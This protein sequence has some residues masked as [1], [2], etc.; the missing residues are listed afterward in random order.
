[1]W[2][3]SYQWCRR[4]GIVDF[5]K[6]ALT[7]ESKGYPFARDF[8]HLVEESEISEAG[9]GSKFAKTA[10]LFI[11]FKPENGRAHLTENFK[12]LDFLHAKKEFLNHY[13]HVMGEKKKK[14][15]NRKS[16]IDHDI[17]LHQK[18][19][20][21]AHLITD[22]L[23][24]GL[25]SLGDVL[26][27]FKKCDEAAAGTTITNTTTTSGEASHIKDLDV[28]VANAFEELIHVVRHPIVKPVPPP[29][30]T[31]WVVSWLKENGFE[32]YQSNFVNQE[33]LTIE[34]VLKPKPISEAELNE[35]IG[36]KKLGHRKKFLSLI[37]EL[38]RKHSNLTQEK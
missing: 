36:I 33:I 3:T 1:M 16:L 37:Q 23:G 31:D 34:D 14:T 27:Y 15:H 32:L 13:G 18:A 22:R 26:L 29:V 38:E 28:V 7:L 4:A 11:E 20:E 6:C 9:F 24:F 5:D 12:L 2:M 30:R 19:I 8:Q 21:F 35:V 17:T 25:V 10:K